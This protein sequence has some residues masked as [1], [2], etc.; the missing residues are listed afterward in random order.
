MN[1]NID[2][3]IAGCNTRCT[4]C[5]VNGGPRPLMDVEDALVCIEK[6]D[7]AARYLPQNT[8]FTLD[9]EPMNHPYLDRI[10]NAAAKTKHIS[11]YHHGMTTGIGLLSRKDKDAVIQTYFDN[12][13]Q[14]FGTTIHGS[15]E[16]HDEIV[17]RTGAYEKVIASTEYLKRK[18]ARIEVSLMFNRF[19][20]SDADAL[21]HILAK[22]D[23]HYIGFVIPIF[24]PHANMKDFEQYRG[25]IEV[26]R[27]LK[28]H[29]ARWNCC[30]IIDQAERHTVGATIAA[31]KNGLK[32]C[33]E[34]QNPQDE[35]YLTLH[36]DCK[37]YV[38]N[39]GAET[40]LLCDLR[41][42]DPKELAERINA[43]PAN[44]DWTAF[45]DLDTLPTEDELI[46]ILETLPNGYIYG[47][48]ES[49]IYRGLAELNVSTKILSGVC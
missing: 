1:I 24:T 12:G 37:L 46:S 9:H 48:R 23:P 47:D 6:L 2:F 44:R 39:T 4:H 42:A 17:R 28:D 26:L 16:H 18:G 30:D 3:L 36:Q 21:D 15:G 49:V 10:L 7:N 31:L 5:Y 11:N 25:D 27:S 29:F 19:F 8:S 22:L 38:G 35:L 33:E 13:Y 43:L 41:F 20:E 45:Y 14:T 32:L 40:E 34:F